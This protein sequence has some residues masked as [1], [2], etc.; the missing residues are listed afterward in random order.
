MREVV[1]VTEYHF[2]EEVPV[3]KVYCSRVACGILVLAV[4]VTCVPEVRQSVDEGLVAT[5][6]VHGMKLAVNVVA[7]EPVVS[8]VLGALALATEAPVPETVHPLNR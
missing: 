8:V 1:F 2:D 3:A 6:I 5:L 4:I 7:A